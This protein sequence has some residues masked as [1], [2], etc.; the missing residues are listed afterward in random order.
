M[1][2]KCNTL[3]IAFFSLMSAVSLHGMHPSIREKIAASEQLWKCAVAACDKNDPYPVI[4]GRSAFQLLDDDRDPRPLWQHLD[5]LADIVRNAGDLMSDQE[6]L[7]HLFGSSRY[8]NR[9]KIIK[10]MIE[11]GVVNPNEIGDGGDV[12][13]QDS[14][15]HRDEEFT[16]Y[17]LDHGVMMGF[18][19][20][21]A[22][23]MI[24]RHTIE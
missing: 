18:R 21:E 23:R 11:D 13:L 9:K 22:A 19:A 15:M 17:L 7:K 24:K 4:F 20:Q 3:T 6:K 8:E 5:R 10:K 2:R 14:I 12:L 16:Q 1:K